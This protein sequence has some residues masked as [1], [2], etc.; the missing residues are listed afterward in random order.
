ML[1][2]LV[3]GPRNTTKPGERRYNFVWYRPADATSELP[4]LLTDATG[5]LH[6][7]NIPPDRIR[8][9]VIVE[10]RAA[11]ERLLAPQFAEVVRATAEP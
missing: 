5:C 4:A 3:A 9:D 8:A 11:A 6:D 2:Y 10:M 7:M 1:G